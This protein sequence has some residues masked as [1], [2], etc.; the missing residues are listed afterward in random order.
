MIQKNLFFWEGIE[1]PQRP[2]S[3]RMYGCGQRVTSMMLQPNLAYPAT[4][5]EQTTSDT[6]RG[7][8]MRI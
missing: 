3:S 8:K 2:N 7:Q 4:A 1:G 5:P 6:E